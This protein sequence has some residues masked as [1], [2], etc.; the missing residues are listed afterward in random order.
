ML[1]FV[2]P[3]KAGIQN[4]VFDPTPPELPESLFAKEG[5]QGVADAGY[6][7][8]AVSR[9]RSPTIYIL[10]LLGFGGGGSVV[11]IR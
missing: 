2:I 1:P 3:A 5:F 8:P 9:R 6:K 7:L 10:W 4:F 11:S